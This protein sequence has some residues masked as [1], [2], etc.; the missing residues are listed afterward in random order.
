MFGSSLHVSILAFYFCL[1]RKAVCSMEYQKAP[2]NYAGFYPEHYVEFKCCN[3]SDKISSLELNDKYIREPRWD[4]FVRNDT[5]V[6]YVHERTLGRYAC[7][8]SST[9][10]G[11]CIHDVLMEKYAPGPRELFC[12][13]S[14]SHKF[15]PYAVEAEGL[16]KAAYVT[17][18][19]CSISVDYKIKLRKYLDDRWTHA[20]TISG[21]SLLIENLH[22]CTS[23]EVVVVT[24]A[25]QES[26]EDRKPRS[27]PTFFRTLCSPSSIPEGVVIET[28]LNSSVVFSFKD[29]ISPPS[30]I[31]RFWFAISEKNPPHD[32]VSL[33]D[34]FVWIDRCHR[35]K[36]LGNQR[37]VHQIDD[38]TP[39]TTY[40]LSLR[41]GNGD[42]AGQWCEPIELKT[43]GK[44]RQNEVETITLLVLTEETIK[45]SWESKTNSSNFTVVI[46]GHDYYDTIST[47]ENE[48]TF[49][50][51]Q[52]STEYQ[53]SIRSEDVEDDYPYTMRFRT[54]DDKMR[55]TMKNLRDKVTDLEK[56]SNSVKEEVEKIEMGNEE[57]IMELRQL[58]EDLSKR[59]EAM[60]QSRTRIREM[61]AELA[62]RKAHLKRTFNS[63]SNVRMFIIGA[64]VLTIIVLIVELTL[65]TAAQ[66]N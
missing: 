1:S 2:L 52:P 14:E 55:T 48:I 64:E 57:K 29:P 27:E 51:L 3:R 47:S 59:T 13:P 63:P 4:T 6:V 24:D 21:K 45:I 33:R 62:S 11:R 15:R 31:D 41:F 19:H 39:N 53:V 26:Y 10:S 25:K 40:Y 46:D 18:K 44:E 17:F 54:L 22:D 37:I 36:F 61:E 9:D 43:L 32:Y 34:N 30:L 65:P 49:T 28:V 7:K 42:A 5:V 8:S 35:A 56:R 60:I 38:L 16:E 20:Y 66:R 58:E 50:H 23:Y 12:N